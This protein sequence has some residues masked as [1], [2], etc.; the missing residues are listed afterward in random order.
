MERQKAINSIKKFVVARCIEE[1]YTDLC[2]HFK[3]SRDILEYMM[4]VPTNYLLKKRGGGEA[5]IFYPNPIIAPHR[6]PLQ[7]VICGNSRGVIGN[8]VCLTL[9]TNFHASNGKQ[10]R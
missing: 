5:R 1:E 6:Y 7:H 10:D 4:R 3:N 8:M 2:A 9:F